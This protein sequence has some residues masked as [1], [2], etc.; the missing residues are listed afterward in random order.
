MPLL[1]KEPE[2]QP[3]SIFDLS[4]RYQWVVAHVRSRQEKVL[5]RH[6][7]RHHIPFYL[8]QTERKT[9]RAGRVFSSYLPLFPG[10]VF[11]RA[12]DEHRHLIWRS[13]VL[14]NLLDVIDQETLDHELKQIRQLQ[15]LGAT[16]RPHLKVVPGD[17][18]RIV[19]GVFQGYTGVVLR[20]R[21]ADRLVVLVSFL[22]KAVAVE[23]E[24]DVLRRR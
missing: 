21:S 23:F 18:V 11:I 8:P 3:E 13:G 22:R 7:A 12:A 10:Y 24:K 19:E 5:A 6:L 1:R 4:P 2:V 16:L 15:I 17:P 9:R 20:E 14:A